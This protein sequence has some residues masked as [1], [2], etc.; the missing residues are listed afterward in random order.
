MDS[1]QITD[2]E[3]LSQLRSTVVR[4]KKKSKQRFQGALGEA[5]RAVG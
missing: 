5:T 2:K 1:F 4:G 3:A